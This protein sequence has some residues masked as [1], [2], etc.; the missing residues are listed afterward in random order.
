[1][2]LD[3]TQLSFPQ[4]IITLVKRLLHYSFAFSIFTFFSLIIID[5]SI[6][7]YVQDRIYTKIE[8]LPSRPYGIV[9][10]TAKYFSKNNPNLYY[11]NRLTATVELFKQEKIDYLL[12]SGD[13]RTMQYNEPI[14]M[15]KDLRK[16]DIPED[17]MYMDF[18]GFRTLDSVIRADKVFK[19]Q[20]MTIITQQ[21]HCERALFIAKFYDIDAI[22]FAAK[23]PANYLSVRMREL[24]AR[25][26]AIL[27]IVL[28]KEPYFL[29]NPEPLPTPIT[30]L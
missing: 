24:F 5:R 23:S 14:T 17:V 11:N 3:F 27:D 2:N 13:N 15:F 10:G 9:L 4:W 29:G 25:V 20:P 6:A 12:L 22:C 18:A 26:K 28:E 30:Q 19:A 16:M 21:F 1:M 7:W 8:E